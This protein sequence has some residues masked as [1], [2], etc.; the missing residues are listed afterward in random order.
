M[1][2]DDNDP[3]ID[4]EKTSCDPNMIINVSGSERALEAWGWAEEHNLEFK[5]VAEGHILPL[6]MYDRAKDMITPPYNRGNFIDA[7]RSD[8]DLDF[9]FLNDDDLMVFK[10]RWI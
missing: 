1:I 6:E 4:M 5:L 3:V 9:M 8:H 2:D 7:I 10:L